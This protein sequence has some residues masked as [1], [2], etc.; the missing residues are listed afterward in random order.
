MFKRLLDTRVNQLLFGCILSLLLLARSAS[1]THIVGGELD[2]QHRTGSI[3][4]LTL[5][6]Y[7]DDVNGS[8][9]ALDSS[10]RVSIF[11][12]GTNRP[13]NSLVL[14]LASNTFVAYT[15]P[16]CES[17]SLRT[18]HLVYR[19][20][21]DLTAQI[22]NNPTGYYAAVERC[23][24]NRTISNIDKPED[25][26]QTFYLEFPPVVRNGQPLIN[27]T[28]QIFPPLSDYACR[29]ELFYYDFGGSDADGDSLV[30]E[31]AEPLNGNASPGNNSP[32]P[33]PA[34][35]S[36][37]KW[38]P[39]FDLTH[40]IPGSPALN[41]DGRSGRLTVR[42]SQLG[43]F[44]F[45][46]KCSEYRKGVKLGE[47]RRD[48]Q[49]KVLSCAPNQTP[50]LSLR[51]P[52][53]ASDYP[54]SQPVWDIK[55]DSDHCLRLRFTDPDPASQLTL[56]LHPVN[57]T[58]TLPTF[59]RPQGTV[60]APGSPDTLTSQLCF[61]SCLD[62]KGKTYLLDVIVADNGC[63][64]PRRDTIQLAFTAAPAPNSPPT[65]STTAPTPL[66]VRPGQLLTFDVVGQDPDQD[67]LTLTLKGLGFEAATV[68]A[69]LTQTQVNQQTRGQFSWRV[70]CP[71]TDKRLYE[72]EFQAAATPC[73][74]AQATRLVVPVE[75]DDR[76]A[77]P[78]LTSTT[79]ATLPLVVR[80]GQVVT[81][82]LLGTDADQDAVTLTL[83]GRGFSPQTLGAQVSRQNIGSD[84]K[85]T[86]RWVVPCLPASKLLYEFEFTASSTACSTQ[87]ASLLIP[88][89]VD[90]SNDA[91]VLTT[92]VGATLPLHVQSGQLLTFDLSATDPNRDPIRLTMAGRGF[93]A[94]TVGAQLTQNTAGTQQQGRFTWRVPCPTATTSRYEF[95]FTATDIPCGT[96]GAATV[97]IP[98]QIDDLNTPPTLTSSLF[99]AAPAA[100]QQTPGSTLEATVTGLDAN[101]DLLTLTARGVGFDLAAVGMRFEARQEA[102]RA[103]GTFR[104]E[105]NCRDAVQTSYD[106]VFAVQET[107]CNPQP[108]QRT[109][110]FTVANPEPTVF[111]PANI[112]TPN[113]DGLNDVF[114]LPTLPPDYCSQRFLIIKV[115]NRWGR[116]VYSSPSR[117]FQWDGSG[118]PAGVYYYLIDYSNQRQ[119]KGHVTIVY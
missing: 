37:V 45:A 46:I 5:N 61:P 29:G 88:I 52:G 105:V 35:Y 22:Y 70:P 84:Y 40:Q 50:A 12:K 100:L 112:F 92:T 44:V 21:I 57:F 110:R 75:I 27:S 69:K 94:S 89:R 79:S 7:F 9:D 33:A 1:A 59:T 17:P 62:T 23:C 65:L 8:P 6:L 4:Q 48:F 107:T 19:S 96:P 15:N 101:A 80:P 118:L 111:L 18:R 109:V 117:N 41:I 25:A 95:E 14:S 113:H 42:P 11:E 51:L 55:P 64:L 16:V 38:L 116:Q 67:A 3:Y 54:A 31:M 85:G 87:K 86:F 58:G 98:I 26:G 72:F 90:L 97:V 20:M 43:L 39:G 56:S 34:P 66:R 49:L 24:R 106:V 99:T 60:R 68:G 2:L 77:P 71:T 53:Q 10:L 119:F 103:V 108:Q 47:V 91:P 114:E 115:F 28:P 104:W 81:F 36:L 30:Y 76:N 78:V 82:D 102:G 73:G 93:V 32:A 83:Q 63:S 74:V 13:M